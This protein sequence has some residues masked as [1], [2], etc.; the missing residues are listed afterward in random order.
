MTKQSLMTLLERQ[1]A[2]LSALD[3]RMQQVAVDKAAHRLLADDFKILIIGELNRGKSSLL[4]AL[5]RQ[6]LLT[7]SSIPCP[8]IN[9]V[10]WGDTPKALIYPNPASNEG[11]Q[12]TSLNQIQDYNGQDATEGQPY[13]VIELYWPLELCRRGVELTEYP[14]L[15]ETSVGQTPNGLSTHLAE[16][17]VVILVLSCEALL[18]ESERNVIEQV[19]FPAGH[20]EIFFVCNRLDSVRPGERD[21]IRAHG[22]DKLAPYVKTGSERIFFASA[23]DA[24]EGYLNGDES[25]VAQS[26]LP[27]L[28]AAITA[29][30]TSDRQGVKIQRAIALAQAVM[31]GAWQVLAEREVCLQQAAAARQQI[32][33]R[34]QES[35]RRLDEERSHLVAHIGGFREILLEVIEDRTFNFFSNLAQHIEIWAQEYPLDGTTRVTMALSPAK[36]EAVAQDMVASVIGRA[37]REWNTWQTNELKGLITERTRQILNDLDQQTKT[38]VQQLDKLRQEVAPDQ[39]GTRFSLGIEPDIAMFDPQNGLSAKQMMD[40]TGVT[41]VGLTDIAKILGLSAG[42]WLLLNFVL[43]PISIPVSA[44]VALFLTYRTVEGATHDFKQQ[45]GQVCSQD[46]RARSR[47]YA[48]QI[49]QSVAEK[50]TVLQVEV[51]RQTTQAL[52]TLQQQVE[53]KSAE[54]RSDGGP[55]GPTLEELTAIRRDLETIE[56]EL[57]T[58]TVV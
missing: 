23:L 40:R 34:W 24:L 44:L 52:N 15:V 3:L 37:R 53:A 39:V 28:E 46:I 22:Y 9:R 31:P 11:G 21:N 10:R 4:N 47:E 27:E 20:R 51:E 50:V 1:Q 30:L 26:G 5:L 8:V 58:Q 41:S 19:V 49:A 56:K 57:E 17:D 2:W 18:S 29:F 14:I 45:V 13:P 7:A 36:A 16:A 32:Y 48:A 42:S 43:P 35:L 25:R 6:E 12:E 55:D 33:A 54:H 38:F